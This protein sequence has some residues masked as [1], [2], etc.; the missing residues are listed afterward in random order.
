MDPEAAARLITGASTY[1]AQWIANSDDPEATSR[2]A[3]QAFKALLN[4][5]KVDRCD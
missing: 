3:V 4:G 1:A 2:I 5:L